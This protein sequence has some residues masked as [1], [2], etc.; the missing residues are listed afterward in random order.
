M[1]RNFTYDTIG[2][3]RYF[4]LNQSDI[5]TN[6]QILIN[7]IHRLTIMPMLIGDYAIYSLNNLSFERIDHAQ[8]ENIYKDVTFYAI[9]TIVRDM[10]E[11]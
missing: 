9:R 5:K 10:D 6:L 3:N 7:G 2:L 4:I 1:N 11:T 8:F